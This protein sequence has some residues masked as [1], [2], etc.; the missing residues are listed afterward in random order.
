MTA[1]EPLSTALP[2]L[3]PADRRELLRLARASVRAA[4]RGEAAPAESVLSTALREPG[5]AFVSLHQDRR[6]RGCVGTL[7]ADRPLHDTVARMARAAALDDPRFAPLAEA[8]LDGV[9]IEISRLSPLVPAVA[10]QVLPGHHGVSLRCGEHRG[11]FLPQ[12]ATVY[13]WDRE[14][15][16]TE[17]CYKA[18]LPADAWMRPGI[19]LMVFTAEVFGENDVAAG[20]SE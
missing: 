7:V 3:S 10:D 1:P 5:A 18:Q 17:L 19:D 15:L 14:T 12:V 9:D 20:V 16:L 2:A 11:V 13:N 4:V 8:E 6:L